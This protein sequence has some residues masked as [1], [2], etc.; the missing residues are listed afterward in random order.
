MAFHILATLI[1]SIIWELSRAFL[2]DTYETA[3][4]PIFV[5]RKMFTSSSFLFLTFTLLSLWQNNRAF[6]NRTLKLMN[7]YL[8]KNDSNVA[9][10]GGLEW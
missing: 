5:P 1:T 10:I 4:G 9:Y 8:N 3:D 2:E 6:K 7:S